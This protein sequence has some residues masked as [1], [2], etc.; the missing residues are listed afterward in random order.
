MPVR[1]FDHCSASPLGIM[2]RRSDLASCR[3]KRGKERIDIV[4][5][6]ADSRGNRRSSGSE[7]IYLE[8][9]AIQFRCEMLRAVAMTVLGE[10]QAHSRVK[11]RRSLD[12]ARTQH[13]EIQKGGNCVHRDLDSSADYL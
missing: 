6:E 8:D 11:L 13:D 2:R 12:V 3:L 5:R 10:D 9:E 7:W 4:D 1:V